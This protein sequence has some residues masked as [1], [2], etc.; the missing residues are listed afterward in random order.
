M[1][2][3]GAWC[4]SLEKKGFFARQCVCDALTVCSPPGVAKVEED[5]KEWGGRGYVWV[6]VYDWR[7][8]VFSPSSQLV[9]IST[10]EA[11]LLVL[12]F[13]I[14][15]GFF[16]PFFLLPDLSF[17]T[18]IAATGTHFHSGGEGNGQQ[19]PNSCFT[20][21]SSTCHAAASSES[22]SSVARSN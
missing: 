4:L 6:C 1:L 9:L 8:G 11:Y 14:I 20:P 17:F 22:S 15:F 2:S 19:A 5:N 7:E 3:S 18:I 10:L 13:G 12:F 16:P 21:P